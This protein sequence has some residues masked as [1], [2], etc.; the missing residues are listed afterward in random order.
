MLNFVLCVP[1][2]FLIFMT[3]ELLGVKTEKSRSNKYIYIYNC[4]WF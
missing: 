2:N 4:D 3:S 1:F